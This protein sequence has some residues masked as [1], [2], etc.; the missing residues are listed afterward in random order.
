MSKPSD[1][2]GPVDREV[3]TPRE[4]GSFLIFHARTSALIIKL[5]PYRT[6][7]ADALRKQLREM[8]EECERWPLTVPVDVVERLAWTASTHQRIQELELQV[9]VLVGRKR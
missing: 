9:N 3:P 7:L 5:V 2:P 6:P 8:A 1:P 4:S